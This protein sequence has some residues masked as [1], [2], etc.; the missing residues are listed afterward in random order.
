MNIPKE[1]PEGYIRTDNILIVYRLLKTKGYYQITYCS[2]SISQYWGNFSYRGW[3]TLTALVKIRVGDEIE[4]WAVPQFVYEEADMLESF[5]YTEDTIK[6]SH[7]VDETTLMYHK[8]E[9]CLFE[10]E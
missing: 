10:E 5:D 1:I 4:K 2:D 9:I 6:K 8:D 3:K 7:K